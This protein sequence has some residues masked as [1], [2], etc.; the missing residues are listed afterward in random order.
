MS[1]PHNIPCEGQ[2]K[3]CIGRPPTPLAPE[4]YICTSARGPTGTAKRTSFRVSVRTKSTTLAQQHLVS[5]MSLSTPWGS[6]R[7]LRSLSI[8]PLCLFWPTLM[9]A[10]SASYV[11][12]ANPLFRSLT[13]DNASH[14]F[15]RLLFKLT[16]SI[17]S[18]FCLVLSLPLSFSLHHVRNGNVHLPCFRIRAPRFFFFCIFT[19][20]RTNFPMPFPNAC[21]LGV[22]FLHR[23]D[24]SVASYRSSPCSFL[25]IFH[26]VIYS[27]SDVDDGRRPSDRNFVSCP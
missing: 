12:F 26:Y 2:V 1:A 19:S 11:S 13:L 15:F 23:N 4:S 22:S 10:L 7:A 3:G 18:T 14:I 21:R 25:T 6:S 27:L 24:L 8:R 17:S 16:C 9:R 20:I 5:P